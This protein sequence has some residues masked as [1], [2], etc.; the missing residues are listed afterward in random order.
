MPEEIAIVEYDPKWPEMFEETRLDLLAAAGDHIED[1]Q[2]IGSTSVQNLAAKPVIDILMGV[3]S[4]AVADAHC[5]EP[6]VGCGFR[7]RAGAKPPIRRYFTKDDSEGNRTHQIHLVERNS[8]WWDRH[9]LF[10]DYLR[11]NVAVR[12]AYEELKRELPKETYERTSDY[13]D[14]KTEFITGVEQEARAWQK[15]N[16]RA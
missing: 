11:A 16:P 7:F 3:L 5:I 12:D 6:T 8:E 4:L 9:I 15:E 13:A 10:R 1:I 2:H 14:R